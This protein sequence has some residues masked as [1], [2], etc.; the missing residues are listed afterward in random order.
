MRN[1]DKNILKEL[2]FP[3]KEV[4]KIQDDLIQEVDD[5]IKNKQNLIVHAPTGLGKSAA[6]LPIALAHAIKSNLTVFFLTSRH[7]QHMIALDTL[8]E[9][10]KIYNKE[11]VAVDII[12]KKWMCP[13][14]GTDELFSYEFFEFCKSMRSDNK[15]EFYV[16]SRKKSGRAA[17]QAQKAVDDLKKLSP[18]HCEDLVEYCIKE[19]L[20]P[21]EISTLLAKEASVIIS[22]Y[23]YIFN[24]TIRE[25]FFNKTEKELSNCI[26]I[27][28]EGHNLPKRARELLSQNISSFSIRAALK[29]ARK[30][31]YEETAEYL[32]AIREIFDN[33]EKEFVEAG[34]QKLNEN[35]E[36]FGIENERLIT[37]KEFVNKIKLIDDYQNL[38]ANFEFTAKEV[39][40][41]QR[42]SYIGGIANFFI[43]W[44]GPDKGFARILS[45]K[46][47][48]ERP[49]ITLSYKCLDPSLL[50]KEIVN[51]TYSTI[52]MS[53]TLTPTSMYKEILGFENTVEKEYSSP[54]PHEN[55]L[56]MIIPDTTTKFTA[57]NPEQYQKIALNISKIV[58]AVPGN[59]IVFFPSYQ[60]RDDINRY[61]YGLCKKTTFLEMP[62]MSKTEKQEL[63]EKFKSY[64]DAG[65]VLLAVAAANFA[66]GIDLP[67]DLLKAVV[68]VG[69]PLQKP[70]LE[71]KELI[72][73]YEEKYKKGWDY[74]YIFPAITKCLQSSGRCIRSETDKG[75]I[76]FLDQRFAWPHYKKCFPPDLNIKITKLYEDRIK[77]F[78]D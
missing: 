33:Y 78:F 49:I 69:L 2:L 51:Q 74:G 57:R 73:Y 72:D 39:R 46:E 76:V 29:E 16:N 43:K 63:L 28:D 24:P 41:K 22:D 12:G 56:S 4:R 26:I 3:H 17:I 10:K 71:T 62:G 38:I 53:G 40:E 75:I 54:F 44:E 1:M 42:K 18:C 9:I 6:T 23:Y 20:C 30:Y 31:G 55:K 25:T 35:K 7:T 14:P 70:D 37:K 58:N 67:G 34:Q 68:V 59:S 5:C 77:E 60:L 48:K 61:F 19:K 47:Y 50:T 65:A 32:V 45:F 27:I 15:C 64:K 21:Y 66:E 36:F 11:I 52:I 13:V 8:K